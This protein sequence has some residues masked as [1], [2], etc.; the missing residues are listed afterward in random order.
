MPSIT[1][2]DHLVA[3]N[4]YTLLHA[5]DPQIP[6][7]VAEL[8]VQCPSADF[9]A[10]NTGTVRMGYPDSASSPTTIS[11]PEYGWLPG[12]DRTIGAGG[13][14]NDISLTERWVQGSAD[15]MVLYV[16]VVVQ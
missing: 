8:A 16:G 9:E 10:A 7:S 12:Q 5:A 6:Q 3:Y 2:V 4:L 14:L 11:K 15:N 13:N 1:L